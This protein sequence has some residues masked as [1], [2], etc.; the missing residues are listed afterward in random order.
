MKSTQSD[1]EPNRRDTVR[2]FRAILFIGLPPSPAKAVFTSVDLY[3][4][5][6]LLARENPNENQKIN[7]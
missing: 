3:G 7:G 5:V 2:V 6:R 4:N 1:T